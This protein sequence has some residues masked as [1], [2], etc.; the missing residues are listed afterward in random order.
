MFSVTI[1]VA[2]AASEGAVQVMVPLVPRAGPVQ[3][4]PLRYGELKAIKRAK[5]AQA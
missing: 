1:I 4:E 2:A 3:E 5:A